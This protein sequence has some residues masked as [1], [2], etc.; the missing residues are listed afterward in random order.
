ME[1]RIRTQEAER[2]ARRILTHWRASARQLADIP[3]VAR[4]IDDEIG[5]PEL[6]QLHVRFEQ[7]LAAYVDL[8]AF[9]ESRCVGRNARAP[10]IERAHAV[11]DQISEVA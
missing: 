9:A 5:R 4:I 1:Q 11:L 3:S 10:Q 2:A 8:L 6:L 7:L